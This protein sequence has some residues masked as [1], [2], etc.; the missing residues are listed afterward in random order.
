MKFLKRVIRVLPRYLEASNDRKV[1]RKKIL[2]SL[3]GNTHGPS[4]GLRLGL[5][6]QNMFE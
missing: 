1:L 3:D 6:D 4:E 5:L 2:V